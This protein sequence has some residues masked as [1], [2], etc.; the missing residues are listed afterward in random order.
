MWSQVN[1]SLWGKWCGH[2]EGGKSGWSHHGARMHV[3]AH[4]ADYFCTRGTCVRGWDQECLALD[5]N[6]ET[7]D[8]K[9]YIK[10]HH[11]G[12]VSRTNQIGYIESIPPIVTPHI[13]ESCL[14]KLDVFLFC[15]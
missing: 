13:P 10:L 15:F 9:P 1:H 6:I 5:E 11:S 4:L 8:A 12:Y 3:Y 7:I 14:L 2:V